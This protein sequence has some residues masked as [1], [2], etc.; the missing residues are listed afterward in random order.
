MYSKEYDSFLPFKSIIS[1]STYE[2]E[3][4]FFDDFYDSY[5][6]HKKSVK[7]TLEGDMLSMPSL[8]GDEVKQKKRIKIKIFTPS[9]LFTRLP[10]LF[11]KTKA[12]NNSYKLKNE[13]R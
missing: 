2:P 12:G 4:V 1:D 8:D 11:A 10:V 9:K 7:T 3:N 13:I 5:D 6:L